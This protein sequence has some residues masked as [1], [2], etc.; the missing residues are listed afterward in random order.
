MVFLIFPNAVIYIGFYALGNH[1][2]LR[3]YNMLL[4]FLSSISSFKLAYF[5]LLIHRTL[6]IDNNRL[7]NSLLHSGPNR[8]KLNKG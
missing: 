1:Q 3:G 6:N 4:P 7:L 8:L 5:K 2:L